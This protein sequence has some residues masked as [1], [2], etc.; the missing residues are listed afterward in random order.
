M[1]RTSATERGQNMVEF[2][3]VVTVLVLLILVIVD[4]G[5]VTYTY[6]AL[7]NAVRE[8]ARYGIIHPTDTSDIEDYARGLAVGLDQSQL[9]IIPLYNATAETIT[10]T[11]IYQFQ[12]G[13]PILGLIIGEDFYTMQA[14]SFKNTE[15]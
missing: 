14:V 2:G 7:S 12:T 10:V 6:I 3:M 4:L 15:E 11:G 8:G 13:S 5:R 1:R 9:T